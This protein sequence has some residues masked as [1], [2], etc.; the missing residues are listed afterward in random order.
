MLSKESKTPVR[1]RVSRAG[2]V[3]KAANQRR[4]PLV[5]FKRVSRQAESVSRDR[6]PKGPGSPQW[7]GSRRWRS[8]K[9]RCLNRQIAAKPMRAVN[10][11][12]NRGRYNAVRKRPSP[13]LLRAHAIPAPP[14]TSASAAPLASNA[15]SAPEIRALQ[16]AGRPSGGGGAR[17][18]AAP[19]LQ[20][21]EGHALAAVGRWRWQRGGG[22][23]RWRWRRATPM[24]EKINNPMTKQAK[25]DLRRDDCK[26]APARRYADPDP[27]H[28][29]SQ[30][31][32]SH[33]VSRN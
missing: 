15:R 21:V 10:E 32:G 3:R 7:R 24:I 4:L 14:K 9:P 23:M 18:Q 28:S 16:G 2:G 26:I 1:P 11:P 30:N 25:R 27:F 33:H 22:G 17:A 12:S 19:D 20:V 13:M 29:S 31:R 5:I 8:G 6:R